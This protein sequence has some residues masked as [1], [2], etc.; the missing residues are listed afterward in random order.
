[1]S[2]TIIILVNYNNHYDT[3]KCLGSIAEAGYDNSVIVVDNNSTVPG[4]DE[5]KLQYPDTVLIKNDKNIGFGR[6]NNVGIRWVL[7]NTSCKY[8]FILNNDTTIEK[9]TMD[10]LQKILRNRRD[11]GIVAPKIVMMEEPE[12]LWYGGGNI[13]WAKGSASL[14]GYMGSSETMQANRSRNVEFA[15]GCAML[16]RRKVL[17]QIGGF[18]PKFFMYEEDLEFCCR[19]LERNWKICYESSSIVKHK[20][21]GSVRLK[22]DKFRTIWSADNPR[23][24]F[25]MYHITKNTLLNMTMHAK[26]INRFKFLT[27]FPVILSYKILQLLFY[28]KC[29]SVRSIFKGI[30]D[31]VNVKMNDSGDQQSL[32]KIL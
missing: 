27:V 25:F 11:V 1:M 32:M 7:D 10:S 4:V 18:E 20:C 12:K 15:S 13:N 14:P 5:V 19:V 26:G 21:Q 29:D 6:A 24:K 28:G 31:F 22:G 17:E 30:H 16:I 2:D 8:V 9:N 3:L 23:S